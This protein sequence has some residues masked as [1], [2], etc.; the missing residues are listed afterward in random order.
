MPQVPVQQ[1]DHDGGDD[2]CQ[3]IDQQRYAGATDEPQECRQPVESAKA[4]AEAR[5]VSEALD[6][7]GQVEHSVGGEKNHRNNSGDKV[8]GPGPSHQ[9]CPDQDGEGDRTAQP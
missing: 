8:E 2:R 4:G 5:V 1:A 7:C 3:R 6:E 9:L